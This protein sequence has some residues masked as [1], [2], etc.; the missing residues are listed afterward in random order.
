LFD[1]GVPDEAL[2]DE[3]VTEMIAIV[4]KVKMPIFYVETK[5]PAVALTF[6]I[7]W[8]QQQVMGVLGFFARKM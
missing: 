5:E 3:P 4:P 6:D 8:G 7:S 2:V 1:K